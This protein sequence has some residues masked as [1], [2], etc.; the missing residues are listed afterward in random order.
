MALTDE[1]LVA[2]EAF[3]AK[4]TA[5]VAMRAESRAKK[6]AAQALAEEAFALDANA[7]VLE[8]EIA[9]IVAGG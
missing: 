1:Q 4:R 5:L 9:A 3:L 2:V 6:E 7:D 8:R